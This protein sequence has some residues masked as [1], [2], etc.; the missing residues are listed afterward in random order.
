VRAL[1]GYCV[2]ICVD[3]SLASTCYPDICSLLLQL[4]V[5]IACLPCVL[6]KT[7]QQAD[8]ALRWRAA[9]GRGRYTINN[10]LYTSLT[11]WRES[12]CD[13]LTT[14]I[15]IRDG[16]LTSHAESD[17]RLLHEIIVRPGIPHK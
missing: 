1:S 16:V 7:Y 17:Y 6:Y 15:K 2:Y 9:W 10:D 13:T 14:A 12:A 4:R 11:V 3:R 8:H 5:K